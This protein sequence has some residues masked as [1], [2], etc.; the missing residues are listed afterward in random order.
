MAKSNNNESLEKMLLQ[1]IGEPDL[2]QSL[3]KY[4]FGI[5][6]LYLSE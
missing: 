4:L 3:S 6:M 5:G 2:N 1:F